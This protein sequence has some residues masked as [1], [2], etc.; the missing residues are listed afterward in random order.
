MTR[1]TDGISPWLVAF[2]ESRRENPEVVWNRLKAHVNRS[3]LHRSATAYQLWEIL[4]QTDHQFFRRPTEDETLFEYTLNIL[5]DDP[6]GIKISSEKAQKGD[7]VIL[8]EHRDRYGMQNPQYTFGICTK[9]SRSWHGDDEVLLPNWKR[10]TTSG[11][12]KLKA[13]VP[14]SSPGSKIRD[15]DLVEAVRNSWKKTW[16]ED[17]TMLDA[18]QAQFDAGANSVDGS[19]LGSVTEHLS[20]VMKETAITPGGTYA[21]VYVTEDGAYLQVDDKDEP[22]VQVPLK[23]LKKIPGPDPDSE[24]K[25]KTKDQ[26]RDYYSTRGITRQIE[27][28]R[29]M[30]THDPRRTQKFLYRSSNQLRKDVETCCEVLRLV[31]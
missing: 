27:Y 8:G 30:L 16:Q 28:L 21:V 14:G 11:Y 15:G 25:E 19:N 6:L 13:I 23:I 2:A 7:I 10:I 29:R 26:I 22:M 18:I 20:Q 31:G 5:Y 24:V 3:R 12:E 4:K 9:I 17:V 1:K